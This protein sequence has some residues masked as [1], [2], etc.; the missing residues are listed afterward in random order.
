M[1]QDSKKLFDTSQTNNSTRGDPEGSPNKDPKN[2]KPN[3]FS[4][5]EYNNTIKSPIYLYTPVK[6]YIDAKVYKS[7]ITNDFID[8][9][10]IYMWFNKT[11]GRV[12]IGSVV[13]G[14]RRLATYY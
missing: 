3:K 6:V 14:S 12:Y 11:T 5:Q 9:S 10:I 7:D 2:N 8:V 13:N 1:G 4:K